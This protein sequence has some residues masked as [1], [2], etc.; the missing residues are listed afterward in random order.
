MTG[1]PSTY[2]E[3]MGNLICDK[4]TEGLSLRR[5]CKSEEF[6]NASTVYVWL[7]RFPAF[8]EQ[9]ARAREAATED[10]LEEMLEIADDP[11]L[12]AQDKRVRIDTRKW[13]MGK[14]KPKKYGEKQ[15]V[16]VG[17]KDGEALKVEGNV[18]TAALVSSL[19]EALRTQKADK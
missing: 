10:M 19:A 2:T 6:P 4:L 17:N 18:D 1:R 5:I 12:E 15:T 7:D 3:E 14:L 8:A 9:Y 11:L 16:D 13:A